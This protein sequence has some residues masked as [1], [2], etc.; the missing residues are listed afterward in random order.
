MI[1]IAT[2]LLPPGGNGIPAPKIQTL[3]DRDLIGRP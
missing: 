2:D 1:F 3:Y